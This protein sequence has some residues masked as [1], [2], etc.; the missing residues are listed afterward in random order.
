MCQ[1]VSDEIYGDEDDGGVVEDE[2]LMRTHKKYQIYEIV[3]NGVDD[4]D[5]DVDC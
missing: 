2:A 1:T 5:E 3:V 4:E